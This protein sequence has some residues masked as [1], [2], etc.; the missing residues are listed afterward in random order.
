MKP[1]A[2]KCWWLRYVYIH[3]LIF[4]NHIKFINYETFIFSNRVIACIGIM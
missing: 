1:S 3:L 2:R 4:N